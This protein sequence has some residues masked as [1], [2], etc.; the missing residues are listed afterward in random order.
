MHFRLDDDDALAT[1]F[2]ARLRRLSRDL[3]GSTHFSFPKGIMLFPSQP[4]GTEGVSLI[5]TEPLTAIGLAYVSDA[6]FLRNPFSMA[7]RQVWRD[8]PVLSDPTFPAYIRTLHFDN[9][10]AARHNLILHGSRAARMGDEGPALQAKVA[11]ALLDEFPYLDLATLDGTLQALA[12][13]NSMADLPP[14]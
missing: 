13:I 7:H 9:D 6:S 5:R 3:P 14:L 12:G 11:E 1:S 4:G 8:W 2:I 10:T